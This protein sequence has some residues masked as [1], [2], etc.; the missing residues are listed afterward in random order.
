MVF[1]AKCRKIIGKRL[2]CHLQQLAT[3]CKYITKLNF[4]HLLEI[5][6]VNHHPGVNAT[7]LSRTELPKVKVLVG[8]SKTLGPPSIL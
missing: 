2:L 8:S 3:T 7:E 5:F 4:V 6:I 1:G